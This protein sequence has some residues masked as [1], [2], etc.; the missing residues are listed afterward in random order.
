MGAR[1]EKFSATWL[2]K[3]RGELDSH[4]KAS[5]HREGRRQGAPAP[6]LAYQ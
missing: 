6:F 4:A 5:F 2:H 3:P 1:P